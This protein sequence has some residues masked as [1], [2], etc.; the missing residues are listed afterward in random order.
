MNKLAYV[1]LGVVLG[2][3]GQALAGAWDDPNTS[4]WPKATQPRAGALN[5]YS[6]PGYSNW[7]GSRG[8]RPGEVGEVWKRPC[9]ERAYQ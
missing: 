8:T 3:G 4:S 7:G 9:D 6:D 1:L 2:V 5:P